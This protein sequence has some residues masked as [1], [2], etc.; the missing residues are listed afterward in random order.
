MSEYMRWAKTRQKARFTL[1]RSGIV[2]L[3]ID[4]LGARWEDLALESRGTVGKPLSEGDRRAVRRRARAD[5]HGG[6]GPPAPT[7]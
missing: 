6:G 7:T 5:R 4:E 3:P 2:P 1:A